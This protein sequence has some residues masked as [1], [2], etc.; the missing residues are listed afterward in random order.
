MGRPPVEAPKIHMGFRLAADVVK[1]I[2]THGQG[3]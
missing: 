1:G 2:R 3:L